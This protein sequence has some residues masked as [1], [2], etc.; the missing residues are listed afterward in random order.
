M[1]SLAGKMRQLCPSCMGIVGIDKCPH[2]SG[3]GYVW[4]SLYDEGRALDAPDAGELELER[5][6]AEVKR[7]AARVCCPN[8]GTEI[9]RSAA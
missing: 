7:L 1:T 9:E 6:R 8:C 5:L 2:C 3:G 4:V